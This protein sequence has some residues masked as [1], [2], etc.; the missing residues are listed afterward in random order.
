VMAME[1]WVAASKRVNAEGRSIDL[2][3]VCPSCLKPIPLNG[4]TRLSDS[5]CRCGTTSTPAEVMEA[6]GLLEL[7][8]RVTVVDVPR[9]ES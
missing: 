6:H 9:A 2:G 8:P 5:L 7:L 1:W 3:V 4:G